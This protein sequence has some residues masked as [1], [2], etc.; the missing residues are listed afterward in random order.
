[1][2]ILL[3]SLG[4]CLA[5]C[6]ATTAEDEDRV[7]LC[8]DESGNVVLQQEPCPELPDDEVEPATLATPLPRVAAPQPPSAQVPALPAPGVAVPVQPRPPAKLDPARARWFLVPKAPKARR[9]PPRRIGKQT[10]PT[11]LRETAPPGGPSF[12]TPESTWRTFLAAVE[13]GDR[14]GAA[15]CFTARALAI[16][17]PEAESFPLESVRKTV[18][19]FERIENGGDAGPFW[20]AYGVRE[21]ERRQWILFEETATGVWKI[22]GI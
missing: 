6:T 17:G 5:V 18:G 19:T 14:A 2:R 11:H 3:L 20:S 9:D 10:F 4:A 21:G 7:H 12:A 1:L 22:A 13:G 16:L 15:A 8:H